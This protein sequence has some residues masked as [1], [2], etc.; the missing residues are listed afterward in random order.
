MMRY[1][2]YFFFA[3]YLL[4]GLYI[5][6]NYGVSID[7]AVQIRHAEVSLDYA[8]EWLGIDR[9]PYH[10]D[11]KL[12]QHRG[13]EYSMLYGMFCTLIADSVFGYDVE[14]FRHQLRVR[15]Y[16]AFLLFWLATIAFFRTLRMR[17]TGWQY[18]LL[19]V[20]LLLL[21][22]RIFANSFYNPKD[23][24]LLDFYIYATASLFLFLHKRN[25]GTLLLHAV[26]TGAVLNTR[27]PAMFLPFMTVI[28]LLLD[29]IQ[30]RRKIGWT[31][32]QIGVYLGASLLVFVALFPYL[33]VDTFSRI[34]EVYKAMAKF[35]WGS[36]NLIFNEFILGTETPAWYIPAWMIITLPL[37][38]LILIFTGL[39]F[40]VRRQLQLLPKLK[41]W[42]SGAELFDLAQLALGLGPLFAVI[43]LGSNLYNGWRHMYFIY[44]SLLYLGVVA[45][46]QIRRQ[47][48]LRTRT[49]VSTLLILNLLSVGH[50]MYRYHPNQQVYFNALAGSDRTKRYDMDYWGLSYFTAL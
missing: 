19:G 38:I 30:S 22:P 9:E 42:E 40:A 12:E 50:F 13:K 7:E 5:T 10:T 28:L 8:A 4:F 33:W 47:T 39:Y 29:I 2:P 20:I 6:P 3:A 15:H 14:D 25:W 41:F 45:W 31:L 21:T 1:T 17:F 49:V 18:P 44:P 27:L 11:D 43:V 23:T 32:A 46:Q 26:A 36:Y 16:V 35:N 34:A 24:I 48:K 37:G